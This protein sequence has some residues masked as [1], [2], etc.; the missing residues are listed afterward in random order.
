MSFILINKP[1]GPTSH[2]IVDQLRRI[3]GETK[4]GHAG[5]LDPFADG[6]L[7]VAVGRESTKKIS[8]FVGLDKEYLATLKLGAVSDSYDMTGKIQETA[9]D[10]QLTINDLQLTTDN[11]NGILNTFIGEQK[12]I[13]PMFSAK[14]ING[15]RLYRL[16]RRGLEIERQPVK[17][18]IYK[19]CD[20]KW[21]PVDVRLSFV[22]SCSSGTY[23]RSLAH[24][25]GQKLGC[26]AYLEK[27]TRTKIGEFKLEQAI[28][29]EKLNKDNWEK[30]VI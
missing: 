15:R 20:I 2:D 18:K 29:L 11:I 14:K 28:N 7:L 9:D 12:Q 17:I 25:I 3:T 21:S 10:K 23:I 1:S 19:I 27:L 6:L 4:I 26:G 16:A 13:P 8:K 24:D 30:Y 5:T 22:V